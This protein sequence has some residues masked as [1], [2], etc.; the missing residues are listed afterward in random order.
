MLKGKNILLGVTAGIA[1][2]KAAE[3]CS[4]LVKAGAG[5]DVI[6]TERA[7]NFINPLVFETLSGRRC[8][9]D[10][11]ARDFKYDVSHISLAKKADCVIIAPATADIIGKIACGIADD[12]LSTTV[13]ACR[14]PMIA[15]PSMNTA[16]YEN[17]AVQR[18]IKIMRE[19]G[20]HITEPGEGH[21]AC[22]DTGRG[23]L[24]E[25]EDIFA[26]IVRACAYEKD[27]AG[28]KVLVTAGAT[29]EPIDPVRYITNHS[30]GRMG[31]AL[32][33]AAADRGA[34]VTLVSGKT[35]LKP[36]RGV[37]TIESETAADMFAAVK[38]E[39]DGCDIVIM[40]AAVADY[41][42]AEPAEEKIKK[43]DGDNILKLK[44]TDDIL[45][46]FGG[47]G[48]KGYLCGFSMETRS[49]L[50]NSRKKL[51]KKN[52]DMICANSLRTDG[53]G[54]G[55][56]TNVI[57]IITRDREISL[58]KMTKTECAHKI[59]DAIKEDSEK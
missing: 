35:N 10:T 53:A 56:D 41:T 5:V 31:Y 19:F 21:L 37:K 17:P 12:M 33:E 49:L 54:F 32:A 39:S 28:R 36:P 26:D 16:M 6:M 13:M 7:K 48:F 29:R 57:T 4:M 22:G 40:A 44:R 38:S 3:L 30:T 20:W 1:A 45:A 9:T 34:E 55:G 50:E 18:N 47:S 11:F 27:F 15:A 23:R 14:C 25:I 42:P 24:A 2:Y 51:E 52:A 58:E 46:Y 43:S 59:L 8:V